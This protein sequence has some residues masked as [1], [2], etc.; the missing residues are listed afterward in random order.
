MSETDLVRAILKYLH[1]VG[2]LAWRQNTGAV[3]FQDAGRSRFVRFGVPGISD[4][5][6]VLPDGRFLAIEVKMARRRAT[7][8]QKDFMDS[9]TDQGGLAFVA[10]SIEDVQEKL[11]LA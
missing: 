4:I 8:K 7:Y 6:G 10:T 9:I 5:L 3:S 11:K 2:I 1:V